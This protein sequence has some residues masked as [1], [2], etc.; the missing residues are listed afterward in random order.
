M[1]GL[2]TGVKGAGD[3]EQLT[4]HKTFG[5]RATGALSLVYA[6]IIVF[7][8]L[9]N[10]GYS[11]RPRR[12]A[13]GGTMNEYLRHLFNPDLLFGAVGTLAILSRVF[14]EN[15]FYRL[16]EHIFL[17]LALG[18]GVEITWTEVLRPQFWD[19]MV[20]DGQWAWIMTVPSA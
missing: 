15:K 14:K 5:T 20:H 9:G 4:A 12:G 2:L 7:V 8:I 11:C 19:P 16:F 17:G 13:A 18:Y 6:L 1:S 10:V 3:Y